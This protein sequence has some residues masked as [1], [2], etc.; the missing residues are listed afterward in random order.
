LAPSKRMAVRILPSRV[1][2]G[3]IL[4]PLA[5]RPLMPANPPLC[6]QKRRL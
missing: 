4:A 2:A 3:L 1:I 6:Q 5:R